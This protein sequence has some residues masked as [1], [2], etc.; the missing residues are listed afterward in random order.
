MRG[1]VSP[2]SYVLVDTDVA[3]YIFWGDERRHA[4]R[5]LLGGSTLALSFM[6]VAE[7][8][9]WGHNN[10]WG[11]RRLSELAGEIWTAQDSL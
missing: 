9:Q 8:Y 5:R 4:Y 2:P 3:S 11:S 6:T 10:H 1:G 7:L